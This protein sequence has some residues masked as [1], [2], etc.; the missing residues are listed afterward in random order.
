MSSGKLKRALE[1]KSK[2]GVNA[3][4]DKAIAAFESNF[5]PY[6]KRLLGDVQ[7]AAGTASAK[8]LKAQ[9]RK[10]RNASRFKSM[11]VLD[12]DGQPIGDLIQFPRV[13]ADDLTGFEFDKSNPAAQQWVK[14]HAAETI[15]GINESTRQ[16][17][18][19]LV[20]QEFD[21]EFDVDELANRIGDL[22]G[23]DARAETIARTETISASVNG[24]QELWD[25]AVEEGL[26]TGTE[27]QEWIITPDDRLCPICEAIE[28][29]TV[30][31]G[32]PFVTDDGEVDGPPAHPRCRCAVG[33]VV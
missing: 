7:A 24:Q 23:D 8:V 16:A 18:N 30:P 32:E 10:S 12:R 21:G 31:L 14:D 15:D 17:I 19:D 9:L 27:S 28:G 2:S 33:L 6:F 4:V 11:Q 26:L 5:T 25:Q 20:A 3:Q 22:I 1:D 29:Q 13:L